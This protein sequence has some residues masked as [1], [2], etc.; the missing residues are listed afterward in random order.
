MSNIVPKDFWEQ[1]ADEYASEEQH[2]GG[3]MISTS[4][5]ILKFGEEELEGNQMCV[6]VTHAVRE[7]TFY[8]GRYDPDRSEPPKCYAFG[9]SEKKMEPAVELMEQADPEQNWFEPQADDCASCPMNEWGS[10]DTGRGKACQQRRRLAVIPAGTY[11]WNKKEKEWDLE[12]FDDEKDFTESDM[13]YLKL[14]VTS[15]KFWSKYVQAISKK[16]GRPPYGVFTRIYIERSSGNQFEV[17][18]EL[19]DVVPDHVAE[20]IVERNAEARETL[21]QS[22]RP[23]RE[24][25]PANLRPKR[26]G[27]Q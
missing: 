22:Y 21:I 16:P 23:P 13:A 27:K 11:A 5:G 20:A 10:S 9:E 6:I 8:A 26:L 15:V 19:I 2:S 1:K 25:S 4:G 7:H 24:D 12:L 17:H 3:Q 18:F 14:P